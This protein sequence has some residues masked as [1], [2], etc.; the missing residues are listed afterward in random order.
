MTPK[1]PLTTN[2]IK[3]LDYAYTSPVSNLSNAPSIKVL[4][5]PI[6]SAWVVRIRDRKISPKTMAD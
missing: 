2:T 3:L 5:L 6:L 1:I 4:I